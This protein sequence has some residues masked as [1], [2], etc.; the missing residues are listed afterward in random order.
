MPES[1]QPSSPQSAGEPGEFT[2]MFASKVL[3]DEPKSSPDPAQSQSGEF[4]RMFQATPQTVPAPEPVEV[5]EPVKPPPIL[6]SSEEPRPEFTRI[7]QRTPLPQRPARPNPPPAPP[8]SPEVKRVFKPE[9]PILPVAPPP[10]APTES[11]TQMFEKPPVVS[12]STP[13]TEAGS[14]TA[15][16]RQPAPHPEKTTPIQPAGPSE[17]TRFFEQPLAAAEKPVDWNAV[18]NQPAPPPAPR[19]ASDFTRMFGKSA[20]PSAPEPMIPARGREGATNIFETTK[21]GP[22]DARHEVDDFGRL[23]SKPDDAPAPAAVAPVGPPQSANAQASP[24]AQKLPSKPPLLL[25][26]VIIVAI[27]LVAGCALY[28]F[29]VHK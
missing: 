7:F 14:F 28:Y 9:P 10:P 15:F 25:L 4:T 19:P 18:Q 13:V 2:R 6:P 27:V 26:I 1:D 3:P 23:F 29:V 5:A 24:V 17:F 22:A 12:G 11:F 20:E 16:F 21:P 8:A